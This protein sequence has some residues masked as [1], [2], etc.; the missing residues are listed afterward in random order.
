MSV[1]IFNI[2]PLLYS[3]N[4]ITALDKSRGVSSRS[5]AP[6]WIQRATHLR[7]KHGRQAY[8]T[9]TTD[10][11]TDQIQNVIGGSSCRQ[12]YSQRVLVC[13]TTASPT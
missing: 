12:F 6:T 1:P 11:P 10:A 8:T 4:G 2:G 3:Y 9:D 7:L 13:T 5:P